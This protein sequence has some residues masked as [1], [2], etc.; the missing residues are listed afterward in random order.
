M[1]HSEAVDELRPELAVVLLAIATPQSPHFIKAQ[2][3]D[4]AF[5]I[6]ADRDQRL[7]SF[8]V[9]TLVGWVLGQDFG[10]G[11]G[12]GHGLIPGE[13]AKIVPGTSVFGLIGAKLH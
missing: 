3:D 1:A 4:F 5:A 12:H 7:R 6:F 2:I 13:L 10:L 11:L 8:T 9:G